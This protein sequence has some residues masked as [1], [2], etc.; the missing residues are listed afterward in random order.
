[1]GQTEEKI[2]DK[3]GIELDP[4]FKN[5]LFSTDIENNVIRTNDER[6]EI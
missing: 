3:K 1:M 6:R 5:L 2:D 4:F